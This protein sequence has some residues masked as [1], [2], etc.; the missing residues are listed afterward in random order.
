MA[1]L[2]MSGNWNGTLHKAIQCL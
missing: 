2:K 1:V